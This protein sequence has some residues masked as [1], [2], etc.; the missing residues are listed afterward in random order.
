MEYKCWHQLSGL[1]TVSEF[2]KDLLHIKFTSNII[3]EFNQQYMCLW[4]LFRYSQAGI[5]LCFPF[6]F[7]TGRVHL[8]NY[9]FRLLYLSFFLCISFLR[10]FPSCYSSIFC[11]AL[12][13]Y[14]FF[15]KKPLASKLSQHL[16]STFCFIKYDQKHCFLFC[17]WW[18][19]SASRC[20]IVFVFCWLC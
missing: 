3:Y 18:L 8:G 19:S 10:Y 16:S 11:T 15:S 4:Q 13:Y 2:P 9:I 17:W 20:S 5:F 1:E 12:L 14:A 6:L 7:T